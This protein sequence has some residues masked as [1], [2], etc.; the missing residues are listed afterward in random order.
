MFPGG[1]GG[2]GGVGP[3]MGAGGG[4]GGGA[5]KQLLLSAGGGGNSGDCSCWLPPGCHF[6]LDFT[7]GGDRGALGDSVWLTIW[8]EAPGN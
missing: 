4:G 1:S 6:G 7:A 2:G 5:G 3:V 8:E